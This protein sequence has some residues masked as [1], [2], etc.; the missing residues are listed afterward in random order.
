MPDFLRDI[1]V[2]YV[3]F[4]ISVTGGQSPYIFTDT[5]S[6]LPNGLNIDTAT[7]E[8]FG[9]PTTVGTFSNVSIRV[10]D[11]LGNF[12]DFPEFEI[13]IESAAP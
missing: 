7:G 11:S 3:G 10:V 9:T 8:V 12:K 4:T 2:V 5:Y 13:E 6:R 1:D